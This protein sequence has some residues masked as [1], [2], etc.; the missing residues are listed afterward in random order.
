MTS[1]RDDPPCPTKTWM[2]SGLRRNDGEEGCN[3]QLATSVSLF[4]C[5][6]AKLRRLPA[7]ARQARAEGR[8]A[9]S[10]ALHSVMPAQAGIHPCPIMSMAFPERRLLISTEVW[11]DPGPEAGMT[12]L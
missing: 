1:P 7:G 3:V 5:Q 12:M 10:I 6:R 2:V 9:G 4:D 11:M 8:G